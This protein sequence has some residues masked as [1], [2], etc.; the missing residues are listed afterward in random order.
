[1]TTPAVRFEGI[2]KRFPGARALDSITFEIA[3]GSCHAVCGEN[4]AGKSTL[5]KILAGIKRADGGSI[6]LDGSPIHVG[7]P[8]DARALG[9]AIVHQELAFCE[10][11][12]VAEN[13]CLGQLPRRGPLL[14]RDACVR[15]AA[16]LLSAVG[17]V[18]DPR[19]VMGQLSV[20]EQQLAQIAAA[21]GEGARVIIF[22]EPTSSL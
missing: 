10:N 8:R 19:R 18:I 1:M 15:H 3:S 7:S 16:A 17:A 22:D 13:L 12:T 4:G 5:G 6:S 9:I 20:A 21:V 2:S 14:D 11:L